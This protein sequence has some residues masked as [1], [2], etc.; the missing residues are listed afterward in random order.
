MIASPA[1]WRRAALADVATWSSGGTPQSGNPAYYGGSIPWATIGDLN[2][3]VVTETRSSITEAGLTKSSAKIVPPGTLLVA[4]YGASI[5]KLGVAARSMATNQAIAT[6][7]PGDLIFSKYLFYFLYGQRERLIS[8]GKGAAQRNISQSVLKSW[9][10]VFPVDL[11]VQRRI[12]DILDDHLSRIDAGDSALDAGDSRLRAL[13]MSALDKYFGSGSDVTSLGELV[14]DITAGKS[15]GSAR[16]PAAEGEWGIIKVSAMTW[17]TFKPEENK[18]VVPELADPRFEIRQGDLLVSRANTSEY[19]GASVLVGP[20]RPR[21]LLSDK[22]LRLTPN[23]SVNAEWLWRALQA[24]SA[25]RQISALATGTKDSMRNI[26]Q[27][28][29][30]K[31][32]LPAADPAGQEHAVQCFAAVQASM[33][34]ARSSIAVQRRRSSALR[35]SLLTVAFSGRL[36]GRLADVERVEELAVV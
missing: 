24:P 25:R 19:V 22:S 17:G 4:M 31:I 34:A 8:A 10:I 26:S 35:R 9:P 21:L 14:T 15:V 11:A 3:G 33:A 20:V 7:I 18:A 30:R 29:L 6:A 5:G 32:L 1:A 23:S 13:E 27:S 12:V 36:T 28:S 2:D 16:A